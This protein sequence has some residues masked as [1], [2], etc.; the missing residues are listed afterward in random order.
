MPLRHIPINSI[1]YSNARG[2]GEYTYTSN[3]GIPRSA[4]TRRAIKNRCLTTCCN[5]DK[6]PPSTPTPMLMSLTFSS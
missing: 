4:A 3:V 2:I 6:V 1:I 5:K